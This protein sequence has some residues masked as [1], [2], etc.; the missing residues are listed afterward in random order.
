MFCEISDYDVDG[1]PVVLFNIKELRTR[2]QKVY[3]KN[4]KNKALFFEKM[5]DEVKANYPEEVYK[6]FMA[7]E[8]YAKLDVNYSGVIRINKFKI[9]SMVLPLSS[10]HLR[11]Y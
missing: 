11:I 8:D 5:E 3:K 10:E 9:E 2:L 1:D 4:K 6:A 7:K